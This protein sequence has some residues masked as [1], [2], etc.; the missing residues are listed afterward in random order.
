MLGGV[1]GVIG[2]GVPLAAG[3]RVP[4]GEMTELG[5]GMLPLGIGLALPGP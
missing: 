3:P 2:V 5:S 4:G 1:L